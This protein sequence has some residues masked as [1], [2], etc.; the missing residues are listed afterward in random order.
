MVLSNQIILQNLTI[1][2]WNANGLKKQR[3]IFSSFL[4]RH[5]IDI[6]CVSETHLTPA[7]P[8]KISGYCV[9]REDRIGPIAS[10]GVA[11]LIKRKVY[12]HNILLP[13]L[14]NIEAVGA[15][16][17][18]STGKF[19]NI[20][21]A[22]KS[23]NKRL[24]EQ[25]ILNIFHDVLP[26]LIIGDLNCKHQMW[27]CRATNSNGTRLL[28]II[29]GSTINI[30]APEEPTY[31]P[32]QLNNLPDILDIMVHNNFSE[33][34]FQHVLT[35]LDSDHLPVLINFF[36]QP[37]ANSL[38]QRLINGHVDWDTFKAKLDELIEL[39]CNLNSYERIES[40][41]QNFSAILQNATKF[42]TF[43]T[44]RPKNN[45]FLQPPLR[46]LK[47]IKQKNGVRRQWQ[48]HREPWMKRRLNEL[49]RCVKREIED[50]KIQSYKTYVGDIN[51]NDSSLWQATKRIL[52]TPTTIPPLEYGN[53][54]FESDV[55]KSN[56]F[57][58]F[59]E[60]AFSPNAPTNQNVVEIVNDSF[61]H[62][63]ATAEL[64]IRF[65]SPSEVNELIRR[66]PLKKAPGSDLIPNIVLKNLTRK[67]VAA[68]TKIF[69]ACISLGYFPYCWK[70]AE[71]I[72]FHKPNKPKNSTSSYRPISLLPTMSKL[73]E[74]IIQKR[75]FRYVDSAQVIL[76]HQF[77]FQPKHSTLH[78]LQR[79]TECIVHGFENKEY[80]AAAFLD[81]SQAFDKVWH[82]G[83]L[84]KLNSL[85]FPLYL[86]QIVR[87]FLSNRTF[88]VKI[89]AT[90]SSTRLVSAGVPQ[91]SILG[92]LLF[93]I[94]MSDMP[95]PPNVEL[96][97]YA[98]D[99]ALIC[100]DRDILVAQQALQN[101]VNST[102]QWFHM[103]RFS[104][105]T[106][107][108]ETKIF[109]L[110][111]L[112]DTPEI[113]INNTRVQW[114]PSDQGVKYLGVHLDRKLNF[115]LHINSKLTQA[116]SRLS[117]LFPLIN[118]TSSLKP[119][120]AILL[121]KSILRPLI[122]YA[123]PVWG[124]S[125]SN[126]KLH[127]IQVFQNK[128]LRIAVNCPWFVRNSQLHRDLG[129]DS[130]LTFIRRCTSKFKNSLH[131]VPGATFF[132]VGVPTMNRRLKRRLMQ[133]FL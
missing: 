93:N 95:I 112:Q 15:K 35:E 39:P 88:H 31:H 66:L 52:R 114:N 103:W 73:L 94:Y 75:L 125:I 24:L 110:R 60:K 81:V 50:F 89:N 76:P 120:C 54:I 63:T 7:E 55:D 86:K 92:P 11:I 74:K 106:T 47:L 6:A 128:V 70:K 91:G 8:F 13:Q 19:I 121:Y 68:L 5:N 111:K 12:H 16:V 29:N 101:A 132:G 32:W 117:L 87:S 80:C 42:A 102:V 57:A 99:T 18:L 58:N 115:N 131:L 17:F 104:L 36:V 25:D 27:G 85:G 109:T 123:S 69:N 78:Q 79:L 45:I 9:Y 56:A 21:S 40:A 100:K 62:T 77:G 105:N 61:H 10:G 71:I 90:I 65:A 133:D 51:L 37:L 53:N 4:V 96:A 33:P 119:E 67:G 107:K 129:V 84:Y 20:I 44:F 30:S 59:F 126:K 113:I 48:R 83:L 22:Y 124:L 34:I 28:Q 130:V 3:A 98:D 108:C 116:Y 26:T 72:V 97:L 43:K 127:K 38:P 46:I 49:A 82:E 118:R 1:L 64:P 122:L 41:I 2:N 14:R 23:P